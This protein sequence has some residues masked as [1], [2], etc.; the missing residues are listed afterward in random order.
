M[1]RTTNEWTKLDRTLMDLVMR[2]WNA[3][4]APPSLRAMARAIGVSAPRVMDLR[5]HRNGRPLVDEF[6]AICEVIGA[7]AARTLKAALDETRQ[8]N[9]NQGA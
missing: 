2:Q 5:D 3:M 9:G 1:P 8:A 6:C 7:D 4:D